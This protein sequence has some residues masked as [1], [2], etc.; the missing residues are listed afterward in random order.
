MKLKIALSTATALGL[1]MGVASAADNNK[2]FLE[3]DGG[4]NSASI[5]QSGGNA[6]D[7]GQAGTPATQKGTANILTY[8]NAGWTS[9]GGNNNNDVLQFLQDGTGNKFQGSDQG[10]SSGN[11]VNS[12]TQD[13]DYNGAYILRTQEDNS[14]V[15]TVKMEGNRNTLSI[16]QGTNTGGYA[17][18]NNSV[19]SVTITG[20]NNG[21]GGASIW[22][23][24]HADAAVYIRQHGNSNQI[25]SSTIEGSNNHD[26]APYAQG[27]Y[28]RVHE[29]IQTGNGNLVDAVSTIGDD[30]N[31]IRLSQA[32]DSNGVAGLGQLTHGF[33][34]S[35]AGA[36]HSSAYQNGT[37]NRIGYAVTG[38]ENQFGFHQDGVNN[39]AI[40][41][42]FIGH[43]NEIGVDQV[44]TDNIVNLGAVIGDSND[45][46]V[47]QIDGG[48]TANIDL[49]NGSDSNAIRIVQ[50]AAVAAINSNLVDI[51]I[52]GDSNLLNVAQDSDNS[53]TVN[54]KGS[55]NN[56]TG[57]GFSGKAGEIAGSLMPGDLFQTG[58]NTATLNVGGAGASNNNLFAF[59]QNG[60]GNVISGAIDGSGGNQAVVIQAGS[61]NTATFA[62]N[63]ASNNVAIKQ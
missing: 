50:V 19:G 38:D 7:F 34:S 11:T 54:V 60:A 2:T 15:G 56:N 32:G 57:L 51:A 42:N 52:D 35:I 46:G 6:N 4:T 27:A 5:N 22:L 40:G 45:I 9:P 3:Q 61:T 25:G 1:L 8:N 29:I 39:S 10:G 55:N 53:M 37:G 33:A 24:A 36:Y 44:G 47:K 59:N 26:A 16:L 17:G 23:H 48:N 58:S 41:L 49:T 14:T 30:G 12:F 21:L 63:G 43:Y 62:Q 31:W 13:G 18:G 20:D 28:N